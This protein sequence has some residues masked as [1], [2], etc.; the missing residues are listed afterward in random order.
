MLLRKED[1]LR[2]AAKRVRDSWDETKNK[3]LY[4]I[5]RA[6]VEYKLTYSVLYEYVKDPTR[7]YLNRPGAPKAVSR[8]D[9]VDVAAECRAKDAAGD[10]ISDADIAVALAKKATR[11]PADWIPSRRTIGRF[12]TEFK[13]K[14]AQVVTLKSAPQPVFDTVIEDW[15]YGYRELSKLVPAYLQVNVDETNIVGK[16]ERNPQFV[17]FSDTVDG[18]RRIII[19]GVLESHVTLVNLI[20]QSGGYLPP[21]LIVPEDS[22]LT[23]ADF[24]DWVGLQ[25]FTTKTGWITKIVY[26]QLLDH[27]NL[28]LHKRLPR[29]HEGKT[30]CDLPATIVVSDNHSTRCAR[31]CTVVLGYFHLMHCM[32]RFADETA[33]GME[34][35]MNL[36][37]A[38]L[39]S[40]V[41]SFLNPL[42]AKGSNE[43]DLAYIC[44]QS[45]CVRKE[46]YMS[47]SRWTT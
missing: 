27:I 7:A 10:L 42:D 3:F 34:R 16:S 36:L 38:M 14:P 45:V 19:Y 40:R 35:N 26:A 33:D 12:K 15:V 18:R 24:P 47:V 44:S 29:K 37:N 23:E 28:H 32:Y 22:G 13:T 8:S 43:P 6:A 17:T 39:P 21:V 30:T 1:K 31:G 4:P 25:I 5:R 9:K 46:T 20:L 41:T 11:K 2:T